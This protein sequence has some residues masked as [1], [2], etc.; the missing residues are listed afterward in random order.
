MLKFI[1]K[2]FSLNL[3]SQPVLAALSDIFDDS[4]EREDIYTPL[5]ETNYEFG[6]EA[7]SE[8]LSVTNQGSILTYIPKLQLQFTNDEN[9]IIY[10]DKSNP[11]N[12]NQISENAAIDVFATIL[13]NIFI[14]YSGGNEPSEH[15][16]IVKAITPLVVKG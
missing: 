9:A 3:T 8:L 7:L 5:F 1:D 12:S 13:D 6:D 10:F 16:A 11:T 14:S 15:D 4:V 2:K